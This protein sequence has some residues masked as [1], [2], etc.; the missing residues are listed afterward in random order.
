MKSTWVRAA[1][2]FASA[3]YAPAQGMLDVTF[4]DGGHFLIATELVVPQAAPTWAELRI[5]ETGDVLEVPAGDAVIEIPWDRI[6]SLADPEFRAHLA[7]QAAQRTRR[8]A[9]RIRAL[10]RAAGLTRAA[11]AEKLG[12]PRDVV[13]DLERGKTEPRGY[14]LQGIASALGKSLRDFAEE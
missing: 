10:R 5:G 14:L 8:L 1:M 2:R 7:A 3:R 4:E 11:L 13:A 9:G 6:R 12:V